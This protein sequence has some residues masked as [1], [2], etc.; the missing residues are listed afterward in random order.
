MCVSSLDF[1]LRFAISFAISPIHAK[2][3]TEIILLYLVSL[4]TL[5]KDCMLQ[6]VYFI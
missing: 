5:R 2:Y 6:G 3:A 4:I 1:E